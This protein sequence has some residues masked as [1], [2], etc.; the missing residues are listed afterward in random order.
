MKLSFM[1]V[2]V[3]DTAVNLATEYRAMFPR[4]LWGR[5]RG[6][7]RKG[8]QYSTD[9][10]D[11]GTFLS[12]SFLSASHFLFQTSRPFAGILGELDSFLYYWN[13]QTMMIQFSQYMHIKSES[14]EEK[15]IHKNGSLTWIKG[16][17]SEKRV[18]IFLSKI[19]DQFTQKCTFKTI[20]Y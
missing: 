2:R 8:I 11:L 6:C 14:E 9:W 18:T 5:T 7:F 1:E 4:Q 10:Q 19:M 17:T 13:S 3:R 15:Q 12:F 20:V 16:E